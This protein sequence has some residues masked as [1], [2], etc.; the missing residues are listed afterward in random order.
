MPINEFIDGIEKEAE[1]LE[2]NLYDE[3]MAVVIGLITVDG[4]VVWNVKNISMVGSVDK[5]V[6]TFHTKYQKPYLNKIKKELIG[7]DKYYVDYFDSI[8][9][10]SKS[11]KGFKAFFTR[12][13]RYLDSIG[14]INPVR[15]E[16]KQYLFNAISSGRS[17]GTIRSGL[18]GILGLKDRTGALTRYYRQMLFDS[19][20]MF[21][22]IVA[23][24]FADQNNLKYFVYEGGVIETTREFCEKRD[25]LIF[26]K[27]NIADWAADPTLPATPG[28]V[29]IVDMGS[30][31]CR[32]YPR[33]ITD[34]QAKE[35][36]KG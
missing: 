15:Q 8:G 21:D 23:N 22:R 24:K 30:Y 7:L 26:N 27:D 12:M 3:I 9:V 14:T 34:E 20:M 2:R 35:N 11:L 17:M 18:R 1:K 5:A 28:Y 29:P 6:D 16:V 4:K 32:H 19:V 33:Y 36:D 25:G 31:N 10:D 13:D